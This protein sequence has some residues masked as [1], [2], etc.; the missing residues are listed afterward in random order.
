MWHPRINDLCGRENV[1][2]SSKSKRK[3]K[4]R[5][6]IIIYPQ[7]SYAKIR[8]LCFHKRYFQMQKTFLCQQKKTTCLP[9]KKKAQIKCA[10]DAENCCA[11]KKKKKLYKMCKKNIL[12][13]YLSTLLS[14]YLQFKKKKIK[15]QNKWMCVVVWNF[16]LL[17]VVNGLKIY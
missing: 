2:R 7:K 17:M 4:S 3:K 12:I 6:I 11:L 16:T 1:K 5:K 9:G 8:K 14:L 15:N 10:L 13:L